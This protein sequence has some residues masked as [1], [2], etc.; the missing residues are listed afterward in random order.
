MKIISGGQ[1]GSDRAVFDFAIEHGIVHGG[2]CPKGWLAEDG[3]IDPWY[4]LT[5]T[6]T[7][8][9]LQRTRMNV[10][11]A[12]GTV[13]LTGSVRLTGGS[14]KTV[15]FATA[16]G[17]P[18]IYLPRTA[19]TAPLE[20]S[21]F[22]AVYRIEIL[23]VAGSRASKDPE[24]Y[25]FTKEILEQVLLPLE[26]GFAVNQELIKPCSVHGRTILTCSFYSPTCGRFFTS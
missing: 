20:F 24:I 1:T 22:L 7:K 13:I 8:Q 12:D 21:K 19:Y 16:A 23:N 11:A 9:Y 3:V 18:W 26:R 17:K 4:Q 5:E 15:E 10:E 14:K 2:W 25:K 6:S